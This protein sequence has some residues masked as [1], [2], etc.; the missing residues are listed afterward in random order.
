MEAQASAE[1]AVRHREQRR[2]RIVRTAAVLV[3]RGGVDAMQMRS[4][5][6][7]SGVA[8][9]TLYRYFPSKMDLVAAV[10]AEEVDRM[11][12]GIARTPSTAPTP[13]GRAVDVLMRATRWLM[14]EPELADALVRSLLTAEGGPGR[15]VCDLVRRAAG[16]PGRGG[17]ADREEPG[18]V[19]AGALASVWVLELVGVLRG[20]RD[21]D[22][23]ERRLRTVAER[24]FAPS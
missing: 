4:V 9:G 14:R 7:R 17:P 22:G 15:R 13:A 2:E 12:G 23:V 5:A 16:E 20:R 8:L 19:L 10:A 1:S 11:E 21:P 3:A 24:L 6:E 18:Q